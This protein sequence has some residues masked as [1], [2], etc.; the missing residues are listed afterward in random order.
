MARLDRAIVEVVHS[1]AASVLGVEI[2]EAS[3]PGPPSDRRL[4]GCVQINGAWSG[5]VILWCDE[6]FA[7]ACAVMLFEGEICGDA[8]TRDALGELTNMVAGNLKTLLPAPSH[9]SLPSVGSGPELVCDA[10]GT[11]LENVQ[12]QLAS[13]ERLEVVVRQDR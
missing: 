8:E 9:L 1:V 10:P 4:A 5:S 6:D 13:G 12:F 2:A 7:R 3:D 11:E